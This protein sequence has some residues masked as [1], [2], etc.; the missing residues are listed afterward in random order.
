MADELHQNSA[1][2]DG[3]EHFDD[4]V[5]DLEVEENQP[6]EQK[7]LDQQIQLIREQHIVEQL[8]ELGQQALHGLELEQQK[9]T[10]MKRE[11][12]QMR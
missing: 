8:R 11:R 5:E 3:E 4:A 6:G 2:L 9:T 7:R 1:A 10:E 12:R